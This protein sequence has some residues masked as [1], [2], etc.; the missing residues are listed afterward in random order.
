MRR[1]RDRIPEKLLE[2]NRFPRA[3]LFENGLTL[4]ILNSTKPIQFDSVG[5]W[6]RFLSD[7]DIELVDR[8]CGDLTCRLKE[9]E[10][11]PQKTV[12]STDVDAWDSRDNVQFDV[13]SLQD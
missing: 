1:S 4:V 2:H 11:A 8:I 13:F 7:D 3:E 9:K 12:L 5:P 10:G 6:A